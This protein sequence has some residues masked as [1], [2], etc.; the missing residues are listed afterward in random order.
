MHSL[1]AMVRAAARRAVGSVPPVFPAF[2]KQG[3][4]YGVFHV[5]FRTAR[6]GHVHMHG[7]S[8]HWYVAGR[9]MHERQQ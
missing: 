6:S 8:R 1:P 4:Q 7:F 3:A 2:V 5:A 9:T